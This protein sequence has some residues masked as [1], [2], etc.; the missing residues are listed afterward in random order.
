MNHIFDNLSKDVD[1]HLSHFEGLSE[2][3]TNVS[4]LLCNDQRRKKVYHDF[5]EGS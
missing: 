4:A 2:E 3:L 1:Q 5:V